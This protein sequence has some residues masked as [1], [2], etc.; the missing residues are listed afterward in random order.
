[1]N[2]ALPQLA[3]E[4]AN[5]KTIIT[6]KDTLNEFYKNHDKMYNTKIRNTGR[7][8]LI[9][10]TPGTNM[11]EVL[12]IMLE[13]NFRRIPVEVNNKIVGVITQIRLL[14]AVYSFSKDIMKIIE[15]RK[16]KSKV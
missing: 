9:S 10:V 11:F 5:K 14:E 16:H 4:A 6:T 15:R 7:P 8:S 13:K 3:C 2:F 1:M 12:K